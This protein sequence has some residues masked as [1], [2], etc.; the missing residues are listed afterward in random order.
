MTINSNNTNTNILLIDRRVSHYEDIVAAIDPVLAI[1]ITFDYY[2]DTFETIKER[3]SEALQLR[4]NSNSNSNSSIVITA[5]ADENEITAS[6]SVGLIQHNYNTPTFEMLL[7]Q[8]P[9]SELEQ[10]QPPPPPPPPPIMPEI[11]DPMAPP[12]PPIMAPALEPFATVAVSKSC[13]VAQVETLDPALESWA[14]FRDF[15]VWCKTECG[16]AHFDLMACALYSNPD[17]KYIIDTLAAPAPEQTGVDIRASTDDTGSATLGG[18]WFLESHAGINVKDAYFT[19]MIDGFRGILFSYSSHTAIISANGIIY[20][21]GY[22]PYGQLGVG[23]TLDRFLP[24]AM[25]LPVGKLA[26]NFSCGDSHTVVIMTDGTLYGCGYNGNG[27]IGLTTGTDGYNRKLELMPIALPSGKTPQSVACGFYYTIVVMTDGTV[28]GMGICS[29]GQ[30]GFSDSGSRSV[31]TTVPLPVGKTAQSAACGSSHTVILMTDGTVYGTGSNYQGQL[32]TNDTVQR[33]ALTE[34]TLPG[35]KKAQGIACGYLHTI[36]VMTDGTVYGTGTNEYGVLGVGDGSNRSLLT[37]MILPPGK[38]AKLSS[39][40]QYHTVVMMTDGTIYGKGYNAYGTLGKGNFDTD[41]D[42]ST[43]SLMINTTGRITKSIA[44]GNHITFVLMTD[45]TVYGVGFGRVGSLGTGYNAHNHTLTAMVLPIANQIRSVACSID[46]TFLL[47]MDGTV[48]GTGDNGYGQLG[49]GDVNI[50]RTLTAIPLPVGKSAQVVACGSYHTVILMTDGTLYATGYNVNGEL[51]IGTGDSTRT[52]LTAM[53]TLNTSGKTVQNIVCGGRFT[54]ALMTDG[55]IYI[56]GNNSSNQLG[57]GNS[58]PCTVLTAILT[59]NI[60]GKIP[61]QIACGND[62]YVVVMTDGTVYACGFNGSGQLGTGDTMMRTTLSAISLGS[63]QNGSTVRSAALTSGELLLLMHDGRIIGAGGNGNGELG[64]GNRTQYL[65]FVQMYHPNNPTLGGNKI[66]KSINGK[67]QGQNTIVMMTDGTVYG[68]GGNAVG[69]LGTGDITMRTTLT[70]MTTPGGNDAAIY[71]GITGRKPQFISC[72]TYHTIVVMTDGTIYGTGHNFYGALGLGIGSVNKTTLTPMTLPVAIIKTASMISCEGYNTSAI[73]GNTVYFTGYNGFGSFG[74]GE[75]KNRSVLTPMQNNTG[76]TPQSVIINKFNTFVLMIDGTIYSIGNNSYGQMGVLGSTPTLTLMENTTGKTPKS[77]ACNDYFTIVLMTDGT[78]YGTGYNYYG[79]LGIGSDDITDRNTLTLMKNTTGKTP[80]S[81]VCGGY[82]TIVL[83]TDGTIYGTGYNGTGHLGIGTSYT[84]FTTLTAMTTVPGKTPSIVSCK[85][86]STLVLMTDGTVYGTGVNGFGQL[87]INGDTYNKTVLTASTSINTKVVINLVCGDTHSVVL[88]SDGTMAGFGGADGYVWQLNLTNNTGKTVQSFDAGYLGTVVMMTDGTIYGTGYN[89]HG[90]LGTN[91]TVDRDGLTAIIPMTIQTIASIESESLLQSTITYNG[92]FIFNVSASPVPTPLLSSYISSKSGYAV[93]S[94]TK[95]ADA[96]SCISALNA[97]TGAIT[98]TPGGNNVGSATITVRQTKYGAYAAPQDLQIV[99]TIIKSPT[100]TGAFTQITKYFSDI[101]GTFSVSAPTYNSFSPN[102]ASSPPP[103]FSYGIAYF[104]NTVYAAASAV[105][106]EF[107]N[108]ASTTYTVRGTGQCYITVSTARDLANYLEAATVNIALLTVRAGYIV[109]PGVDLSGALIQNYDLSGTNLSSANFTNASIV[110]CILRNANLSSANFTRATFAYNAI[111]ASTNLTNATFSNMVSNNISGTTA[112]LDAVWSIVG[113][114]ILATGAIYFALSFTL[115]APSATI[116]ASPTLPASGGVAGYYAIG[117]GMLMIN[118]RAET[119]VVANIANNL[120]VKAANTEYV[121]TQTG[122]S[123]TPSYKFSLYLNSADST[124]YVLAR[125]IST[126]AIVALPNVA[127]SQTF[128]VTYAIPTPPNPYKLIGSYLFGPNMSMEGTYFNNFIVPKP[129]LT[130]MSF[131]NLT[132]AITTQSAQIALQG[133]NLTRT[134][135]NSGNLRNILFQDCVCNATDFSGSNLSS[136][137]FQI[138]YDSGGVDAIPNTATLRDAKFTNA[139]VSTLAITGYNNSSTVPA[140]QMDVSGADFSGCTID[141]LRTYFLNRT[142]GGPINMAISNAYNP[143][144]GS[145]AYEML[146]DNLIGRFIAGP[147]MNLSGLALGNAAFVGTNFANS[148][149]YGTTLSSTTMTGVRVSTGR[150]TYSPLTTKLPSTFKIVTPALSATTVQYAVSNSDTG[151]Y[152]ISGQNNPTIALT[153][154]TKYL[155]NISA[156]GHPFWI[157][158]APTTGTGDAYTTGVSNNGASSATIIFVVPIDAPTTLYYKCEIHSSMGGTFTISDEISVYPSHIIGPGADLSGVDATGVVF[159][160]ANASGANFTNAIFRNVV[161]GGITTYPTPLTLP[162]AYYSLIN[163]YFVGPYTDL[164]GADL[165]GVALTGTNLTGANLTNA[166]IT[167]ATSGGIS[168]TA[169]IGGITATVAATMPAGYGL[170]GGYIIGPNMSFVGADLSGFDFTNI[171]LTGV[172]LTGANITYA[173]SGNTTSSPTTTILPDASHVFLN[174]YL[175]GPKINLSGK[176]L[177]GM[178]LYGL[179]LS[180]SIFTGTNFSYTDISGTIIEGSNFT[181]ATFM[182]TR[183]SNIPQPADPANAPVFTSGTSAGYVV[184]NGYLVGANVD[185]SGVNFTGLDL[186]N[187]VLTNTNLSNATF[188]NTRSGGITFLS[189]SAPLLPAKYSVFGGYLHGPRVD[190]SGAVLTALDFSTPANSVN[191]SLANLTNATFTNM[192]SGWISIDSVGSDASGP[193]LSSPYVYN[194]LVSAN[195]SG[196]YIIGPRVSLNGAVLTNYDLRNVIDITGVDFSGA[197]LTGIKTSGTLVATSGSGPTFTPGSGYVLYAAAG[198]IIGPGVD[199]SGVDLSGRYFGTSAQSVADGSTAALSS[200][201]FTNAN[202]TRASL[203]GSTVTGTTF[204]GATFYRTR[205]GGL[206]YSATIP[207]TPSA[208][209]KYVATTVS[210]GY[211][212]GPD[213]DLTSANLRGAV[214]ANTNFNNADLSGADISGSISDNVV[215]DASTNLPAAYKFITNRAQSNFIVGPNVSLSG[216][217]LDAAVIANVDL[218]GTSFISANSGATPTSFVGTRS[219][220]ITYS[221]GQPPI[222]QAGSGYQIRAGYLV[223]PSVDMSNIPVGLRGVDLSGVNLSSATFEN[224]DLSGADLSGTA[225]SYTSF[226]NANFT[227]IKSGGR[228]TFAAAPTMPSASYKIV[229]NGYAEGGEG[230]D[231]KFQRYIVGPGASCINADFSGATFDRVDLSG[232]NFTNANFTRVSSGIMRNTP[233]VLPAGYIIAYGVNPNAIVSQDPSYNNAAYFVGPYVRLQNAYLKNSA[234]TDCDVTGADFT[235]A[236]FTNVSSARITPANNVAVSPAVMPNASYFIRSGYIFG[237][238]V[239]LSASDLSGLD[240][241]GSNL[242]NA[243]L[244]NANLTNANLDRVNISYAALAGSM[245]AGALTT[246][247]VYQGYNYGTNLSVQDPTF[248]LNYRYVYSSTSAQG[249]IF[250]PYVR[251]TGADLRGANMAFTNATGVDMSGAT[252]TN[253]RS[254]NIVVFDN[255]PPTFTPGSGY[256]FLSGYLIGPYADLTGINFTDQDFSGTNLTGVDFTNSLLFNIKSGS[257]VATPVLPTFPDSTFVLR[258][259]YI[260]GPSV[261]L[262]NSDLS[263]IDLSNV[264]ITNANL[265][266]SGLT[267][268]KTGG[269]KG[270]TAFLKQ[271]YMQRNGYIVGNGVDLSG[272]DLS[273]QNLASAYFTNTDITNATLT[274]AILTNVRSGGNM[275][276]NA[277]TKA[278]MPAKYTIRGTYILGPGVDMSGTDLTGLDVSNTFLSGSDFTNAVFTNMRSGGIE[279]LSSNPIVFGEPPESNLGNNFA[280][281]YAFLNGYIVGPGV[282]LSGANF[283]G[284]FVSSVDVSGANLTNAVFTSITSRYVYGTPSAIT[285]GYKV[286]AGHIIGPRLNMTGYDFTNGDFSGA[287]ITS[288]VLTGAIFTNTSSG[289]VSGS[290]GT[291]FTTTTIPTNVKYQLSNGYIV[292]PSVN[293]SNSDLS[294]VDIVG[295]NLTGATLVNSKSGNVVHGPTTVLPTNYTFIAGFDYIIGPYVNLTAVDFS[296]ADFRGTNLTGAN[297]GSANLY[298]AKS[299]NIVGVPGQLPTSFSFVSGFFVGPS[300][301]LSG[302]DLSGGDLSGCNIQGADLTNANFYNVRSGAITG[303]PRRPINAPYVITINGYIVGPNVNLNGANFASIDLRGLTLTNAIITNADFS[304]TKVGGNIGVPRVLTP[305]YIYVQSELSGGYVVGPRIDLSGANFTNSSIAAADLSGANLTNAVFYR[306]R[307]GGMNAATAAAPSALTP[308]YSIMSTTA[309]GGYLIGPNVDLS[310]ANFSNSVFTNRNITGAL[311]GGIK[312]SGTRAGGGGLIG[313]PAT[314][315]PTYRI[316]QGQGSVSGGYIIGPGID[317]SGADFANTDISFTHVDGVNFSNV[318]FTN[319]RTGRMISATPTGVIFTA[320]YRLITSSLSGGYVI[321]PHV[322]LQ[323]ANFTNTDISSTNLTGVN[324]S[325]ATLINMRSGMLSATYDPTTA[326]PTLPAEYRYVATTA[327]GGY[328]VGPSLDLTGANLAGADLSHVVLTGCDVSR[329]TIPA[330][331]AFVRTGLLRNTPTAVGAPYL[332]VPNDASGGYIVGPYSDLSGANLTGSSISGADVSG[333]DFTNARLQNMRSGGIV[334]AHRPAVLP[335]PYLFV[336]NDASGAYIVGPYSDLS[337]ANLTGSS[338]S[339]ADVSGA[340]FTGARLQNMRSGGLVNTHRPAV[341][342]PPY[343]FVPNDASGGY[344]VGPY[345]D[346]SGANLTGS[347]ITGADVSGADFTNARLRN[348]RSGGLVNAHRPAV[349]PA[350]YLFVPNDASGAYIVGPYSDLSGANLAGSSISGAD[351]SGADFTGA[352]LQNMRSGGLVNTHRPAVLPAP[353]LFIPNDASGAYI[354]GPYSDLSG[355]NLT[356]SSITGADVSGADFTGARL[357]DMK[358]GGLEINGPPSVLPSAYRFVVSAAPASGGYIIGPGV[359]LTN[360]ALSGTDL[361]GATFTDTNMQGAQLSSASLINVRSGGVRGSPATLPA[362]YTIVRDNS[363]GGY[364]VGEGVDLSGADLTNCVL[365]NMDVSGANLSNA[366]LTRAKTG[367]NL[368]GPP[369]SFPSAEYHYVVSDASGG[370]LIGPRVDIR[371]ANLS[372][373]D[374]S[375]FSF[376]GANIS[377]VDLSATN[378]VNVKSGET[379]GPPARLPT[380]FVFMTDNSFGGY[381]VGPRVDL[382]GAN[383]TNCRFS[384]LDISGAAFTNT[385]LINVKSGGGMIGPPAAGT[386]PAAYRYVFDV[387]DG[388]G[389]YIVGPGVDLSGASLRNLTSDTVIAGDLNGAYFTNADLTRVRLSGS[390]LLNVKSGGITGTPASLPAQYVFIVSASG[391]YIVGPSADLSGANL[392]NTV[393]TGL[394]IAN[395]DLTNATFVNTRTGALT[396]PPAVMAANYYYIQSSVAPAPQDAYIVGPRVDLS[397]AVLSRTNLTNVDL[398]GSNLMGATFEGTVFTNT[399]IFNANLTGIAPFTTT[400]RIQ[401]LKNRNNRNIVQTRATQCLGGEIDMIAA[402][403]AVPNTVSYD[404]ILDYLRN[405]PVDILTVDNSGNS[406][407]SAYTGSAFYIPSGPNESFY[408]DVSATAIM[409]APAPVPYTQYYHDVIRNAVIETLTGNTIRSVLV[410]ER[411]FLIFGGSVLGLL[412]DDDVYN[413]LGFPGIYKQYSYYGVRNLI[414]PEQINQVN[415]I[416]GNG[417]ISLNWSPSYSDGKPRL[418]YRIE[419]STQQPV[420]RIYVPWATFSEQY[421]LTNATVA[422]LT[423]GVAYYFRVAAINAV[424]T[425]EF[426]NTVIAVPGTVPDPITTLFVNGGANALTLEWDEPYAQGYP[427]ISYGITYREVNAV[428]PAAEVAI[429][430]PVANIVRT[431]SVVIAPGTGAPGAPHIKCSYQIGGGGIGIIRNGVAYDVKITATNSIGSG[432]FGAMASPDPVYAVA[433][434]GPGKVV[435]LDISWNLIIAGGGG[436]VRLSWLPLAPELWGDLPVYAYSIQ[437]VAGSF[438]LLTADANAGAIPDASWNVVPRTAYTIQSDYPNRPHLG[439]LYA[440]ISGLT[441]GT[442]Y[443]FR[444]AAISGVGRGAY[445][446]SGPTSWPA[447]KPNGVIVPGST[448]VRLLLPQLGVRADFTTGAKVTVFWNK[449]ASNGYTVLA[450]RARYTIRGGGLNWIE[451]PEINVPNP[452]TTI[453]TLQYRN[454]AFTGLINGT[455]YEFGVSAKNL[456]GWSDFSES[457]VGTP[458]TVPDPVSSVSSQSLDTSLRVVWTDDVSDGGYPVTGYKVQYATSANA[459]DNIW[460]SVDISGIYSMNAIIPNLFNG[461]VYKLRVLQQ[462]AIG[463]SAPSQVIT[464]IPG[465]VAAPPIGLFLLVGPHRIT[466][467]WQPPV[468]EG[469]NPVEYYYLQYKETGSADDGYI[470]LKDTP[471]GPP[472]QLTD[473]STKPNPPDYDGYTATIDVASGIGALVN[474]VEYSVR[475]AAITR[476]GV[477]AYCVPGTAKPG[478]VPSQIE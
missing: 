199:L 107:A 247:V 80:K 429:S 297:F 206:S 64:V 167:N 82:S 361:S 232:V 246:R 10:M 171:D 131:V 126:A 67:G 275:R 200:I 51:G 412:L 94:Y 454:Y 355:A 139:V 4:N 150:L 163:G 58:N 2:T 440:V 313:L 335:P 312:F 403:S 287:D 63:W 185:L 342:P 17:W 14:Q 444:I 319:T 108:P 140:N 250:G 92:A 146:S 424:G 152:V 436:S 86:R 228:I 43:I 352:R 33:N 404:P 324:M 230:S 391:G 100:Y 41:T 165:S 346:L 360:A 333:A 392:D 315:D 277:T 450:Y 73:I 308:N 77:I 29:N 141:R 430:V 384:G 345:S 218:T 329:A 451:T 97:S 318:N 290:S 211:I 40:G 338:I 9:A 137:T 115:A 223:G 453:N 120:V 76:K 460:S 255:V 331:L 358:S 378:L 411:P 340:N 62:T 119:A 98:F 311:M 349:L 212:I 364:I 19:D 127:S 22:N 322:N 130:D 173:K 476:V 16:A 18:N 425:G 191:W 291:L 401:L 244:A 156:P 420:G 213:V 243:N 354:V 477:G 274:G 37:M 432:A 409:P 124:L 371:D 280:Y 344:I 197:A 103:V 353:Y 170:T 271:N 439:A 294:G 437:A 304:N 464:Q 162:S 283:A 69:E 249:C 359:D 400:Q 205:T 405:R 469:T 99:L 295:I 1:G 179:S 49:L 122:T 7:S 75:Y 337:G 21:T 472:K 459:A 176:D 208:S 34:M 343:L 402:T 195:P 189:T 427:I 164:S 388:T 215:Y 47:L 259:G 260:I 123:P 186:S 132:L 222:F 357:R 66:P 193:I 449:P 265:T 11:I 341:L 365:S 323:D 204:T 475:V 263:G 129:D 301:D 60:G 234:I 196:G 300:T 434:T 61:Q 279:M 305:P 236:D 382:S 31:L 175:L 6:V 397:G 457:I 350:P 154:G 190:L 5:A 395:A 448:P 72:G 367:P 289:N 59:T 143:G 158:T 148:N 281:G 74:D 221:A 416:V 256:K 116:P 20:A 8:V 36:V 421:A 298:N 118:G 216:K 258:G 438:S 238:A 393:L 408:V 299:G 461:Q 54:L 57:I 111:D 288:S 224:S 35:A 136:S 52:T 183:S 363:S 262:S 226:L 68:T 321:G 147:T 117:S 423:N 231:L 28:Y 441:N 387:A 470:F 241:S 194:R 85:S 3:I 303:T 380:P 252:L 91:D 102:L 309:S 217:T 110:N 235:G 376:A 181:G 381:I 245:L 93:F 39:C 390:G 50:R 138:S 407:L 114:Q 227:N 370:F 307:S 413:A 112:Q 375:G 177:S 133:W 44:C 458:R 83:M 155:F 178:Q 351:V 210:G 15:I 125:S 330:S 445:S 187:T 153:R 237:P 151:A 78:I 314:L 109:G 251:A 96:N 13:I 209:Y 24:T 261:D 465:T 285:R 12:P 121:L 410:G 385:T 356:G 455:D 282:D 292:G 266:N 48:Y 46:T 264:T 32:G 90:Q 113:G 95:T 192:R 70:A 468:D 386:L 229:P 273:G 417:Q 467:Y 169:T 276:Y 422:G 26:R 184:R 328:I 174:K 79:Q 316:I 433:G 394:N 134:K 56:T 431:S 42:A 326:P 159:T 284:A 88:Y 144:S 38:T 374:L 396:G 415:A 383:L 348:M 219:G 362:G 418:G 334:N 89:G 269:V 166:T 128:A 399:S 105:T 23:D 452:E 332:F 466:A 267:N 442:A 233:A 278:R 302:A 268:I 336:P 379:T 207:T 203:Y 161:S 257:V 30:F 474:G 65:S 239:N 160:G 198:R 462:N 270:T 180:G 456:L 327:S 398:S 310:G 104:T 317:L 53:S 253:V 325:S 463:Y 286:T 214:F 240:L 471:L 225:L 157:K 182:R 149:I 248:P 145:T 25:I 27:Q 306:T 347:S 414:L 320:P 473:T 368:R 372:G 373:T 426:S 202:L 366:T 447:P 87:G 55:T 101:S 443:K 478:T 272:A 45:G 135:L 201:N 428:P 296:G 435:A 172:N 106:A 220:G 446:D 142:G 168:T 339:G 84:N 293:L 406:N 242:T 419:Y 369:A 81:V 377:N 188:T 71:G 254:G 389:G